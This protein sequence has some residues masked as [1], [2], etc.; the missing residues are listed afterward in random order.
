MCQLTF[1]TVSGTVL[2]TSDQPF[3]VT[4]PGRLTL[5]LCSLLSYD[6]PSK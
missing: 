3:L 4:H 5:G 6:S 2:G 1:L